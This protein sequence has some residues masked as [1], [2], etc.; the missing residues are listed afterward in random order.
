MQSDPHSI[1]KAFLTSLREGIVELSRDWNRAAMP[2]I[3]LFEKRRAGMSLH[4]LPASDF[5]TDS[6]YFFDEKGR[7]V[8]VF[9]PDEYSAIDYEATR[10][11]VAGEFSGWDQAIG[12]S[13]WAMSKDVVEGREALVL[14]CNLQRLKKQDTLQFKFVTDQGHWLPVDAAAPNVENDG[15]GNWNYLVCK[16]KSGRHRLG[17]VLENPMDLSENNYISF[18]SRTKKH[19]AAYLDP[20]SFFYDLRS[21]KAMGA[22]LEGDQTIFR[23]FAPRAKWV[24]VGVFRE[25]DKADSVDW[26]VME[27]DGD[28]V[29]EASFDQNLS[30]CYYWFRLDGPQCEFS[31]FDPERRVLDPYAK[32][33]VSREG[34]GI[35][36]D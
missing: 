29:W 36:I 11:F 25:L 22:V 23:L 4:P 32:A 24:K 14:R 3:G 20:G 9:F 21:E 30:G 5:A 7:C 34:P 33:T 16:A 15:T 10:V 26:I 19:P 28:F 13:E 12:A 31:L 6:R 1:E 8:F 27:R 35:V 17:F 18:R 2:K